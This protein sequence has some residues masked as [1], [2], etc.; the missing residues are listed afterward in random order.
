M[1]PLV[2]DKIKDIIEKKVKHLHPDKEQ[3]IIDEVLR[4]NIKS[5]Y[6]ILQFIRKKLEL[7]PVGSDKKIYW[8]KRGW[9]EEEIET[10]RNIKKMPTS[11]MKIENWVNK[12][13]EKTGKNFTKEEAEYKIKSFR[14]VNIE[15]WLERGYSIEEGKEHI[16]KFQK[17]NSQKFIAKAINN[18]E[19]YIGRTQ[20]QLQYWIDKGFNIEDAKIKLSERQNTTS[21]N[22][23]IKK[24]GEEEG[25]LRYR[26]RCDAAAYTS[27][28]NFYIDKYG[29]D[30]GT[31]MYKD[32]MEKRTVNF[33]KSSK[34]AYHFFVPIYKYLRKSGL[35]LSDIYW[36][37]GSSNEW[38]IN[39]SEYVFFYDFTIKPI[40]LIIEYHGSSFHPKENDS[41]WV[42][43]YGI[44]YQTQLQ[45][46]K[47]KERI[48]IESG[49]DYISVYSD[50]KSNKQKSIIE[51]ITKKLNINNG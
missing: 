36:G 35:R 51:Y 41:N 15:Y 26:K 21:I 22:T 16:K 18:P 42:S 46:D 47:L 34:E 33:S 25:L 31:K 20:T 6:K 44:D 49:F 27:S 43:P 17:E 2:V 39:N 14:K 45:I 13:N 8:I 50:D 37:V 1:E 4:S 30:I 9:S 24:Y 7:P 28:K 11:P 12:I 32:I 23:Y 10:K 38:F 29:D 3:Y 19:K 40:K 5:K 48:A